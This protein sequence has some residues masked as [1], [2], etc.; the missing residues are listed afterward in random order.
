M[1][2]SRSADVETALAQDDD[3]KSR[4]IRKLNILQAHKENSLSANQISSAKELM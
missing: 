3:E 1:Q 4:N 2:Q